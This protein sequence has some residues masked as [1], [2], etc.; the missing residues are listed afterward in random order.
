MS[1]GF[2]FGYDELKTEEK[3]FDRRKN[4]GHAVRLGVGRRIRDL[5]IRLF[6][7]FS[8]VLQDFL[9]AGTES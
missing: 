5:P 9:L 7:P 8:D 4:D 1:Y 6:G 2:G 3:K